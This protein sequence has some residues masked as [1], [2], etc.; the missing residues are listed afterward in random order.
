MTTAEYDFLADAFYRETGIMA[1]GKDVAPAMCGSMV[2]E[3][4]RYTQWR[5]WLMSSRAQDARTTFA[6]QEQP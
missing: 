6:L 2:S 4:Q 5:A 1:P 3:E